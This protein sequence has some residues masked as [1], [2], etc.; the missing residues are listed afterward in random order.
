MDAMTIEKKQSANYCRSLAL[1]AFLTISLANSLHAQGLIFSTDAADTL[2]YLVLSNNSKGEDWGGNQIKVH[3]PTPYNQ[4]ETKS[5]VAFSCG[6]GAYTIQRAVKNAWSN[7]VATNNAYSAAYLFNQTKQIS[8]NGLMFTD[9]FDLMV[10]NGICS[11]TTFPNSHISEGTIPNKDI[12]NAAKKNAISLN[13][14][15]LDN[16]LINPLALGG[17]LRKI[18][19]LIKLPKQEI[20]NAAATEAVI[21]IKQCLAKNQAVILGAATEADFATRYINQPYWLPQNGLPMPHAML[22]IGYDDTSQ[23][24]E[25]MNSYG[26]KW[27]IGGYIR[28]KYSDLWRVFREA[29]ILPQSSSAKGVEMD[30]VDLIAPITDPE[31]KEDVGL[32][33]LKNLD[34]MIKN[35]V[36]LD[37]PKF[38]KTAIAYNEDRQ[39]YE[40]KPKT[41]QKR[42]EFKLFAENIPSGKYLYIFSLDPRETLTVH[43][44]PDARWAETDTRT[45]TAY[46][47]SLAGKAVSAYILSDQILLKI[48][49]P[50]EFLQ[51]NNAG[52][53]QLIALIADHPIQDFRQRLDRF[54][55]AHGAAKERLETV[56]GDVLIP[57]NRLSYITNALMV[58]R[59]VYE[60]K[61][62]VVPIVLSVKID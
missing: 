41:W 23:S 32:F 33:T 50:D 39:L 58:N 14:L 21:E 34:S 37:S 30:V 54:K 28:L 20:I 46:A 52:E 36:G 8:S 5:C 35:A 47:Q 7:D 31:L 17:K 56:F 27:G 48:P 4:G 55:S 16:K 24:F 59:F 38:V 42:K 29:Y 11:A 62:W 12:I 2:P 26:T 61:G 40:T 49:S 22:I 15:T 25:L 1:F 53:E 10:K 18:Y 57:R 19:S 51:A 3:C 44:P 13:P 60:P 43:W 45:S 6:Y 9:V